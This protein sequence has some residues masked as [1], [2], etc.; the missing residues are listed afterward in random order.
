MKHIYPAARGP[1]EV[2]CG[3]SQARRGAALLQFDD[4]F[5]GYIFGILHGSG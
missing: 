3:P 1:E 2:A 4:S 5:K